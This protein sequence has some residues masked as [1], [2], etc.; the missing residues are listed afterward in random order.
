MEVLT[1]LPGIQFYTGN[2]LD[3]CPKGK[4]GAVYPRHGAFCL[5]TQYYPNSPN[6]LD[7]PSA[8]LSAGETWRSKTV[9]RFGKR[10]HHD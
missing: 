9:Y 6:L 4:G 2:F 10:D 7:F 1:T 8:V 3:G 5:E